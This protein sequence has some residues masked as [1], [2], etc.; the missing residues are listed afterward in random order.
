MSKTKKKNTKPLDKIDMNIIYILLIFFF[1]LYI[2]FQSTP[3]LSFLFGASLFF[4]III[5]LVMEFIKGFKESGLKKNIIEIAIALIFV[6]ALWITLEFLL[7]T[8]IP[9][10]VVPSCS[11]LPHLQRGDLIILQGATKT[12]IHAPIINVSKSEF[13]NMLANIDNES[14]ACVSYFQIGS[15]G[16]ITQYYQ[17]GEQIGFI[18][19]SNQSMIVPFGYQN[20][21]LIKYNCGITN[22]ILANGSI[23]QEVYTNS[24]TINNI[25]INGDKNNSII[26][27]QTIPKDLFYKY[28]DTYI[29][30]RVYAILNVSGDYYIL[31]KGDNN[32]G[33][34]IEYDNMP[35]SLNQVMGKVLFDV[36]YLGYLKLAM[37]NSFFEPAGCNATLQDS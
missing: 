6:I 20:N 34:D 22:T 15:S 28:G 12:N 26:V 19:E 36:P 2:I 27:Y 17:N 18:K 30:H 35:P 29:V 10:D 7:K 3:L 23:K 32:P 24:I 31:T 11:M 33:L 14:L 37:S 13:N 9:I 4:T 1:V 5:A 25:T 16:R 8:T 21:N